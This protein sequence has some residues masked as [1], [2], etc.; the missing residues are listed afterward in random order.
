MFSPGSSHPSLV[1]IGAII[2]APLVI[3]A[4]WLWF[5]GRRRSKIR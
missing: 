4:A 2:A 5:G 1:V 3:A